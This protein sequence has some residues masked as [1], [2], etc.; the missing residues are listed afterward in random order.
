MGGGGCI[1]SEGNRIA[2]S[3]RDGIALKTGGEMGL[4]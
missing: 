4:Q 3:E 2:W 1:S